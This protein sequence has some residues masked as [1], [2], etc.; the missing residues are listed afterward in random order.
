MLT[1]DCKR[2]LD[3]LLSGSDQS[4]MLLGWETISPLIP[5]DLDRYKFVNT[6]EHLQ[7]SGYLSFEKNLAWEVT[8]ISLNHRA[9]NYKEV[10]WLELRA[11]LIRSILVPIAVSAVTSVVTIWISRVL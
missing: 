3:A 1:K 5:K 6:L 8:F 2:I 7:Q 10:S 11:F 9:L 4:T